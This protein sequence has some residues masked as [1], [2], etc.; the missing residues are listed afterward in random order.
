MVPV[1]DSFLEQADT[2]FKINGLMD[3]IL[4]DTTRPK[5]QE[6]GSYIEDKI[7]LKLNFFSQQE[8]ID[9]YNQYFGSSAVFLSVISTVLLLVIVLLAVWSSLASVRVMVREFTINLLVG[10]SH[11]R[12]RRLLLGY[13]GLLSSAA[14]LAV[15]M[16]VIVS[17]RAT[18]ECKEAALMTYGI[19]GGLMEMDWIAL[20]AAALA[21]LILVFIVSQC[22]V[23]RIRRVPISVGVL[24]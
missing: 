13:Y 20:A 23:W 8:N 22:A 5:V 6:L 16:M 12:F 15:F 24:Q 10:L 2:A 4:T 21:N 11:R 9:F 19:V 1:T 18:L 7:A 14:V 17:R 3:L